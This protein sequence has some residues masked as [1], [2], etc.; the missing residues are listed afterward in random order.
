MRESNIV[1]PL[2]LDDTAPD[3]TNSGCGDTLQTTISI[4]THIG[5]GPGNATLLIAMLKNFILNFKPIG[6]TELNDDDETQVSV[7]NIAQYRD[8]VI[9]L[10]ANDVKK[11]TTAPGG[12]YFFTL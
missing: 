7:V 9:Q 4:K 1:L 12:D 2:K 11:I 5:P 8:L 10:F 3:F 6:R